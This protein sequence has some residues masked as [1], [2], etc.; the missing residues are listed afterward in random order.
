MTEWVE[1]GDLRAVG[2]ACAN[3][4]R[5]FLRFGAR[6]DL[7]RNS[8][9]LGSAFQRIRASNRV[10]AHRGQLHHVVLQV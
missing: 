8:V 5:F 7:D 4:S 9:G 6:L 1:V 3:P 2:R 10:L